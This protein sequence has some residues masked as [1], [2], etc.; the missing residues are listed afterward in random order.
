MFSRGF[1]RGYFGLFFFMLQSEGLPIFLLLHWMSG[2]V[3]ANIVDEETSGQTE[4][5][6]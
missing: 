6:A 5:E 3:C 2:S 4:K 1:S